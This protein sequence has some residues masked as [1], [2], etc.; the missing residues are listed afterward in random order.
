MLDPP[1][2]R[3]IDNQS[4]VAN[5]F[6][7][8]ERHE[9]ATGFIKPLAHGVILGDMKGATFLFVF[10]VFTG[11]EFNARILIFPI[12]YYLQQLLA[13]GL[14]LL[15]AALTVFI[16]DLKEV[17]GII[18]Q[19]WFWFTPIVYVSSILPDLVKRVM[20]WP[21][22]LVARPFTWRIPSN[23]QLISVS[24]SRHIPI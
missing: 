8:Q 1:V 23:D 22:K 10:L 17:V 3:H 15:S 7:G 5:L 13:F 2:V 14:G 12:I 24:F 6:I 16:R 18:I 9:F 4:V 19:L 21:G 11:Y 20:V